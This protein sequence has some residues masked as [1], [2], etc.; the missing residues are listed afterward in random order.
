MV[1]I[2]REINMKPATMIP[3]T[4]NYPSPIGYWGYPAWLITKFIVV[5]G[6][7]TGV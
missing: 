2:Y 3:G 6:C 4:G 5:H 7:E 1:R